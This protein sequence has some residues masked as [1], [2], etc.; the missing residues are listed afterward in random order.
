MRQE[1][2]VTLHPSL[3]LNANSRLHWRKQA[4]IK[5]ALVQFGRLQLARKMSEVQDRVT[6][7]FHFTFPTKRRRDRANLHPTAKSL[8]DGIVKAG[9]LADDSDEFIDGP[10]IVI[11]G[12]TSGNP[13]HV[14]VTVVIEDVRSARARRLDEAES[15]IRRDRQAAADRAAAA[16]AASR[17]KA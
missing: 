2:T 17:R 12:E 13:R 8:L 11:T 9:V 16:K 4:E 1:A 10:D 6:V 7:T 14:H 15:Q 5:Q 3:I